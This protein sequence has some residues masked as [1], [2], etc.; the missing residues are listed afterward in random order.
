MSSQQF[1][2]EP[3][4][5]LIP[6]VYTIDSANYSLISIKKLFSES[7]KIYK[8]KFKTFF[9]VLIVPML[10]SILSII[11]FAGAFIS[12]FMASPSTS[13]AGA[14]SF[15]FFILGIA[16]FIFMMV[17]QIWSQIAVLCVIKD[18]QEKISIKEA[19]RR[20]KSKILSLLVVSSWVCLAM[21][22]GFILFIIP[23]VIFYVW[24]AFS[25]FVLICEDIKGRKALS[26]S[27]EYVKGRWSKVFG[28]LLASIIVCGIFYIIFSSIFSSLG[29]DKTIAENLS[30]VISSLFVSPF[31]GIYSFLLYQD[32][33]RTKK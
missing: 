2:Q 1:G 28:R 14:S 30:T 9:G 12:V 17:I 5:A 10:I 11:F 33:K 20:S 19:Y 26:K 21:F 8:S 22:G 29:I 3:E 18:N 16:F 25:S 15:I 27:K 23:G 6:P 31:F 32:L 4:S 7:W 13:K 24:F